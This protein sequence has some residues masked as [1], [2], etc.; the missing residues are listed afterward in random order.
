M[1][2]LLAYSCDVISDIIIGTVLIMGLIELKLI[3]KLKEKNR[4]PSDE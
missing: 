2:N 4:P 3:R 1:L